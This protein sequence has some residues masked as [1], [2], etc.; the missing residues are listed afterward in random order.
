MIGISG[1]AESETLILRGPCRKGGRKEE[2]KG[3]EGG[4]PLRNGQIF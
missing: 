2:E 1:G 4:G 3:R